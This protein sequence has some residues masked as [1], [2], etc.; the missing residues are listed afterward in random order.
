MT[1]LLD[2]CHDYIQ[3]A[4]DQ[5]GEMTANQKIYN[6]CVEYIYTTGDC[7]K[8]IENY[9]RSLPNFSKYLN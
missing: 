1:T 2:L 9:L 4:H 7:P 8:Y 3:S 5:S 6:Y